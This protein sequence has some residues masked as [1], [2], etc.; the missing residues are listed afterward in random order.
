MHRPH[1]HTHPHKV[2]TDHHAPHSPA[3][4][5]TQHSTAH[6]L[7]VVWVL[8]MNH[9]IESER[10]A[11]FFVASVARRD[12]Q[13]PLDV[14][15]AQLC[16]AFEELNGLL[17]VAGFDVVNAEPRNHFHVHRVVLVRLHH[18]T[19]QGSTAQGATQ[20]RA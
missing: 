18:T 15:G 11:D 19:A 2:N 20:G 1:T 3:R 13:L 17:I 4:Q 12:H 7:D 6:T 10:F 8:F 9:L 5:S 16:G 14:F